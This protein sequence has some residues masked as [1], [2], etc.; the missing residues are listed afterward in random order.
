M[1]ASRNARLVSMVAK[2]NFV[3]VVVGMVCFGS[4]G[5]DAATYDL[6]I[7]ESFWSKRVFLQPGSTLTE[8]QAATLAIVADPERGAVLSIGSWISGKWSVRYEYDQ[9]F[10]FNTGTIRGWFRTEG[11]VPQDVQISISWYDATGTRVEKTTYDL[12]T[13]AAWTSFE[14]P[15]RSGYPGAD[16]IGLAFGLGTKTNGRVL[17]SDLSIEDGFTA[18]GAAA[19][20]A[21][22]RAKPPATL[23]SAAATNV[24]M[25]RASAASTLRPKGVTR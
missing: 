14:L 6:A 17:F 8:D 16:S 7:Q 9:R 2:F 12:G 24:R 19:V 5:S 4:T 15:L 23:A 10:A 25:R 20:S 11:L 3:A 22:V 13:A 21:I 1:G 18:L